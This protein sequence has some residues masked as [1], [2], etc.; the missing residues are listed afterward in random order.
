MGKI[1]VGIAD[2]HITIRD[3]FVKEIKNN[4]DCTF[5]AESSNGKDFLAAIKASNQIPHIVSIDLSMPIMNGY[6][7]VKQMRLLYPSTKIL[8]FTYVAELDAIINLFNLGINGFITKADEKFNFSS[9]LIEILENGFLN[10]KHYKSNQ[11]AMLDWNKYS[12]IG[13]NK[14]SHKE[15]EFI[16]FTIQNLS[17]SDIAKQWHCSDKNVDYY[18]NNIY[19]QLNIDSRTELI[20]YAQKIGYEC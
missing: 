17:A 10:N 6:D 3:L 1:I 7:T 8:V 15:I 20:Q 5:I 4:L 14:F 11:L 16:Q 2:D 9:A 19:K 13:K 18:R 12:F